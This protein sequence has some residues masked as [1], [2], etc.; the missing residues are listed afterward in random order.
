[1]YELKRIEKLAFI[2]IFV[3]ALIPFAGF[4]VSIIAGIWNGSI[5]RTPENTEY[6]TAATMLVVTAF[7]LNVISFFVWKNINA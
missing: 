1:M 2:A 6:K 5:Q 4:A 3:G 7:I